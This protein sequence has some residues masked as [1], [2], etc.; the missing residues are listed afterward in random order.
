MNKIKI[1]LGKDT[2]YN[3]AYYRVI[4]E[5]E[6][7][8]KNA[9]YF[10]MKW[11]RWTPFPVQKFSLFKTRMHLYTKWELVEQ[12]TLFKITNRDNAGIYLVELV[13]NEK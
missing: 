3:Y 7:I 12:E 9:T 8:P 5:M 2:N 6:E 13:E 4:G 10:V 11:N 1:W